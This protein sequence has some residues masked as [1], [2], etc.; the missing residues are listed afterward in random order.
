MDLQVK[1]FKVD[2]S[3]TPKQNSLT[4]PY[5]HPKAEINYS[6]PP[7]KGEDYENLIQNV[8][9]KVNFFKTCNRRIHFLLKDPF[10]DFEQKTWWLQL[11]SFCLYVLL[12]NLHSIAFTLPA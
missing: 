7:V 3:T 5:H 4:G 6:F 2:I 11:L 10:G 9:L 1:K 8:L 12:S